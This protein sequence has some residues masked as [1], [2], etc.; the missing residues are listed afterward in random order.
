MLGNKSEPLRM[1]VCVMGRWM[2]STVQEWIG[3]RLVRE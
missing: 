2:K 3:K 1:C